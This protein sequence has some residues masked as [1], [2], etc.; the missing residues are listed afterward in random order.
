MASADPASQR[1]ASQGF[2][3]PARQHARVAALLDVHADTL[4]VLTNG[5][6]SP[7][8]VILPQCFIENIG[9]FQRAIADSGLDGTI[10]YAKKANKADAFV[11]AC[12]AQGIGVDVASGGELT[13]ALAAGVIGENIGLSGPEKTDDLLN[14]ALRH[15][16]LIAI[17]SLNELQRLASLSANVGASARILLRIRPEHEPGSR[18]GLTSPEYE[19]AL[20]LCAVQADRIQ[21][22]GLSFHLGGYSVRERADCASALIDRCLVARAR[23]LATCRHI[24]IGGGLPVQYLDPERW[25][26]FLRQ[27]EPRHY[28]AKKSFGGFYPYGAA[29]HGAQALRDLLAHPVADNESLAHKARRHRIGLIVEPGRVLLDQAGLTIFEVQGVK[30]RRASEGYAII[31]VQGSSLSLS[32]QWFNSEY[33]PDPLLLGHADDD[34][35][36]FAACVGGST[37]L[38][39]D[40]VTWRKIGLPRVVE[41]GDRLVYLNTAGYQMDSNESPLHEARLPLKVVVKLHDDDS[42]L[43]WRLDGI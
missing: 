20:N 22:E 17:D 27:D 31:T 36:A 41:P 4:G 9:E 32:E 33:L 18:F 25:Q 26:A 39:S 21:L 19:T 5:L 7:L 8:H 30:D 23:G 2:R 43:H 28:H 35:R 16:C 37:C 14:V 29:R 15:H 10:L 13:K 42:A 1:Q 40:M 24:D 38:E 11:R 34:A 3:L 12:A 6:G